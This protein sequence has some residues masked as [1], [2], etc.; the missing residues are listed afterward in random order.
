MYNLYWHTFLDF[1]VYIL[2]CIPYMYIHFDTNNFLV[3]ILKCITFRYT[4]AYVFANI[5]KI[6]MNFQTAIQLN[7]QIKNNQTEFKQ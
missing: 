7:G 1:L 2:K 6:I 5:L 4:F 3:Y